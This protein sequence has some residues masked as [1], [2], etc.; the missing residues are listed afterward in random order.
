MARSLATATVSPRG[1]ND[2]CVTHEATMADRAGPDAAVT[3]YRPPETRARA[4]GC[5]G[6]GSRLVGY[7]HGRHAAA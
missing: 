5:K 4:W 1:S 6:H 7:T 2:A 3:T